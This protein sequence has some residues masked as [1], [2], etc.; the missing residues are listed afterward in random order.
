MIPHRLV[1]PASERY[2]VQASPTQ[3]AR[4][5]HKRLLP[6]CT[7]PMEDLLSAWSCDETGQHVT[8]HNRLENSSGTVRSVIVIDTA[9]VTRRDFGASS[10]L[11]SILA[12]RQLA[13]GTMLIVAQ[14]TQTQGY[15]LWRVATDDVVTLVAPL[16]E[17]RSFYGAADIS[18]DGTRI[19]YSVRVTSGFELRVRDGASVLLRFRSSR[20]ALEDYSEPDWR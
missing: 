17:L 15:S 13:D 19:A 11:N 9:G 6:R 20:G 8:L 16:P 5:S 12:V 18:Y 10:G 3:L 14:R 2:A 4:G 7:D 1:N